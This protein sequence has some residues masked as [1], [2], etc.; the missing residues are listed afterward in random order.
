[1]LN[2]SEAM[3]SADEIAAAVGNVTFDIACPDQR[4]HVGSGGDPYDQR[5][6]RIHLS[7]AGLAYRQRPVLSA[8]LNGAI[9][10]AQS[11]CRLTMDGPNGPYDNGNVAFA[12]IYAKPQKGASETLVAHARDYFPLYGYWDRVIDIYADQEQTEALDRA[13]KEQAAAWAAQTQATARDGPG[14]GGIP[15]GDPER[16]RNQGHELGDAV[17]AFFWRW[18]KIICGVSLAIWL[19][20]RREAIA[21]WYYSLT[22]HP[23]T[24]MLNQR[25]FD[26]SPLDDAA[27]AEI[28]AE[29]PGNDIE[30]KVRVA[31]AVKLAERARSALEA[32]RKALERMK[33][34]A[35]KD[36]KFTAAQAELARVVEMY[37]RVSAQM[38]A[39][40]TWRTANVRE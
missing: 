7:K 6:V 34:Q 12:D 40:D 14:N 26:G 32:N 17:S 18:A 35:L 23:A 27:F 33:A 8:L 11:E 19:F 28:M 9:A 25:L 22:P 16:Q 3:A 38:E 36:A 20:N 4:E 39:V 21:E 37:E 24:A 2:P 10:S 29:Q 1:M 31:Q 15:V 30:R 5:G 13:K